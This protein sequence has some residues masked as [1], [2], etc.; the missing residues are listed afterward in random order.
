MR[1]PLL[2]TNT[3]TLT[4]TLQLNFQTPTRHLRLPTANASL[5]VVGSFAKDWFLCSDGIACIPNDVTHTHNAYLYL[6]RPQIYTGRKISVNL[7]Y[8]IET[9]QGAAK[10]LRTIASPPSSYFGWLPANVF[11]T[12]NGIRSNLATST[13]R[14]ALSRE[15]GGSSSSA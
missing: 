8:I 5:C 10:H 4:S 1:L 2:K 7:G 3:T 15:C 9:G 12:I 6:G 14:I 13:E 11:L